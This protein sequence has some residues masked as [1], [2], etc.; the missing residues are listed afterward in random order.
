VDL[1]ERRVVD[2][3][4]DVAVVFPPRPEP[5]RLRTLD[6]PCGEGVVETLVDDDAA[7]RRA[8]LPRGAERRPHDPV[9]R[10]VEVRVVHHDDRVL[11]AE[12]E[13]D[14]LETV[15]GRLEHLDAGLARAGER[16]HADVRDGD[17]PLADRASATVDDVHD[18]GG[19]PASVRSS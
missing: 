3:W 18:A 17:E 2:D 10:E 12:L 14:V 15:R 9:D 8:P 19:T 4:T 5:K 7:R 6:E 16:D 11:A 1:L 13:V